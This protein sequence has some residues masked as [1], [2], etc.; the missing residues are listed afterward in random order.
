LIDASSGQTLTYGALAE[1]VRSVAFGLVRRG[2]GKGDVLGVYAPNRVE[3]AVVLLA[4]A[5]LGG[6]ATTVNHLATENDLKRQLI[7]AGAVLLVT[8]PDLLRCAQAAADSTA[9]REIFVIGE[10]EGATAFSNLGHANGV[11]PDVSISSDD[12]VLL[13]YSSGTTGLPKGVMIT[14]GTWVANLCQSDVSQG[15]TPDEEVFCLP[16]FFH[17]YGAFIWTLVLSGGGTLVLMPRFDFR[18]FL[19]AAQRYRVTRAYLVPPVVL[20]LVNDPTV[21]AYDLASLR[22]ITSAA[23]PL[24][25]DLARR[26]QER[27]GCS[28]VQGYGL[29]ETS[30]ATH[31]VPVTGRSIN[32]HRSRLR[33]RTWTESTGR[34]ADSGTASDEGVPQPTRGDCT[35]D[36]P[37]WLASHRR[38]RLCG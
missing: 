38:H 4:V 17:M 28:V 7:D 12:V 29:T 6:I 20:A 32:D 9:V 2:F 23:A 1:K 8:V 10:A 11:V 25:G 37:G 15:I 13:P 33:R 18:L 14:H 16:P 22:C 19:E 27:L 30:P 35:D 34:I 31:L 36:Y 21:E 3:Y 24:G 5:S 26:C